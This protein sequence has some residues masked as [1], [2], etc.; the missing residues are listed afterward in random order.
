MDWDT[1]ELIN[2]KDADILELK[3]EN[4]R[5]KAQ[6]DK[7]IHINRKMKRALEKYAFE[8]TKIEIPNW[9]GNSLQPRNELDIFAPVS[10]VS[11]PEFDGVKEVEIPYANDTSLAQD[12]LKQIEEME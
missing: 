4:E 7:E 5:L 11:K 6:L 8:N 9:I 2:D 1:V 10:L 12:T 3:E